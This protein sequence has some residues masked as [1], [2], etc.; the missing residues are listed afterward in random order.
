MCH[1][2]RLPCEFLVT[3]GCTQCAHGR[4]NCRVRSLGCCLTAE[5]DG[6]IVVADAR[7]LW[8]KRAGSG[9]ERTAVPADFPRRVLR[10]LRDCMTMD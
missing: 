8:T 10:Q 7:L 3:F 9:E 4:Q 1:H 6:V 2:F 5:R